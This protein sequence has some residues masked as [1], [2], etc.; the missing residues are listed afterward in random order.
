M[1][2][3]TMTHSL[4][5]SEAEY[6]ALTAPVD[7]EI[8]ADVEQA[9][10]SA[11]WNCGY[12]CITHTDAARLAAHDAIAAVEPH[13]RAKHRAELFAE[14]IEAAKTEATALSHIRELSPNVEWRETI[15]QEEALERAAEWLEDCQEAEAEA[16]R[17]VDAA[18]GEVSRG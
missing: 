10:S 12:G 8:L 5:D 6:M 4:T 1:T 14:L 3:E 11:V 18:D 7:D 2:T 17:P 15:Q 9:I 16:T 13:M